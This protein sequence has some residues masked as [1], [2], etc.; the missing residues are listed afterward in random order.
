[1]KGSAMSSY[2]GNIPT[3]RKALRAKKRREAEARNAAANAQVRPCGHVHG[4]AQASRC[5]S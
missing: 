2:T 1:M 5:S 4:D 3:N